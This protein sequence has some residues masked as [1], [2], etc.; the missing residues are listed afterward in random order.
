MIE[1]PIQKIIE[2]RKEL[3]KQVKELDNLLNL[4]DTHPELIHLVN[5]MKQV[6]YL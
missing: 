6:L 3:Q 1:D 4:L 2:K 5:G